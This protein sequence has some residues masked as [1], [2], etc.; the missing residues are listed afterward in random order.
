MSGDGGAGGPVVDD[1]V[2]DGAVVSDPGARRGTPTVSVVVAMRDAAA[3]LSSLGAMLA[4]QELDGVEVVCVDDAS[5][6]TTAALVG[7]WAQGSLV[8]RSGRAVEVTVVTMQAQG[9]PAAARRAG[10]R[11][12]RG[13]WVWFPDADDRFGPTLLSHL[14]TTAEAHGAD[15]VAMRAAPEH[16]D[17]TPSPLRLY[18]RPPPPHPVVLDHAAA[19]DAAFTGALMGYLWDKLFSREL[20]ARAYGDDVDL[21][22]HEDLLLVLRCLAHRPRVVLTPEH[23]YRYVVRGA[24]LSKLPVPSYRDLLRCGQAADALAAT[25]HPAPRHHAAFMTR[26]VG[27]A[28]IEDAVRKDPTALASAVPACREALRRAGPRQVLAAHGPVLALRTTAAQLAPHPYARCYGL[29]RAG[30]RGVRRLLRG[31]S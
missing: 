8:S 27:L 15:L 13:R 31:G 25:V 26:Y 30:L 6:D 1:P 17:A 9:G 10:L 4:A 11:A 5:T 28:G 20:L 2:V 21:R 29:L 19:V 12:A 22:T 14:V 23:L 16:E 3:H 18:G 7:A 24:S